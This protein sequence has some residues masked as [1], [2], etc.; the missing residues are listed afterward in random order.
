MFW[1]NWYRNKGEQLLEPVFRNLRFSIFEKI[2]GS[3]DNNYKILD[4]GC[5]PEAQFSKFL[6]KN[7]FAGSYHGYD[8][9]LNVKSLNKKFTFSKNIED[10]GEN[11]YNFITMFAVLEHLDYPDFDFRVLDKSSMPGTRL[12]LTTP[13]VFSKPILELL[14][15][16]FGIVSKRE[17]DEHKHYY[18]KI[19][20][21]K[22][23]KPFGFEIV[24]YGFF[25]LYLNQWAYLKKL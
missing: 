14:S 7:N 3:L 15:Q 11:K 23:F 17:I 19:D 13:T 1:N 8:P 6:I 4:F 2:V 24:S 21:E 20:I 5:G 12:F 10:I 18:N 22:V 9:L 16:K 25:E